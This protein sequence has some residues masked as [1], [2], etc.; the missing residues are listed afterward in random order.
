MWI[1]N[2][3]VCGSTVVGEI[4]VGPRLSVNTSR[5]FVCGCMC[6]V[7]VGVGCVCVYWC[8]GMGVCE[9]AP[10]TLWAYYHE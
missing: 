2:I 10:E 7:G 5:G 6:V 1:V 4:F 8:V 9:F 3:C